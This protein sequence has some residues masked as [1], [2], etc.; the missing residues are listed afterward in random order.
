MRLFLN[1]IKGFLMLRSAQRARLEARTAS[2]QPFDSLSPMI[3]SCAVGIGR[4]FG[5]SAR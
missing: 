5:R 1:A 4:R 2:I 3:F